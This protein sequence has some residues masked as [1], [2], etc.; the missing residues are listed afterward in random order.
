MVMMGRP[1]GPTR[2]PLPT[3]TPERRAHIRNEL[4]R[5]GILD[6]EPHGW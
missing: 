1:V 2:A 4:E 3:A 6:S 5:L